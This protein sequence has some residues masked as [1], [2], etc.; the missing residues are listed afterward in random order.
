[1][2]FRT[3]FVSNSSSSSFV[4]HT[5]FLVDEFKDIL[6]ISLKEYF[7]EDSLKAKL[8]HL[9]KENEEW[10]PKY[11]KWIGEQI[12][13]RISSFKKILKDLEEN[14]IDLVNTVFDVYCYS[15][16]EN[17][18]SRASVYGHTSMY[19]DEDDIGELLLAIRK[20]LEENYGH[21]SWMLE[22]R[23]EDVV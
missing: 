9:I 20:M 4:L 21:N 8:N 15:L 6:Q 12:S 14:R 3:G 17:Q 1:M 13:E 11:G 7:S 16:E 10:M 2:K 23:N 19:N 22:L 5:N 18:L